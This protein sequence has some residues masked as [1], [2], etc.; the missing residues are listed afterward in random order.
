[1]L[2]ADIPPDL[3]RSEV[4]RVRDLR[5]ADRRARRIIGD[6]GWTWTIRPRLD[7]VQRRPFGRLIDAGVISSD[8]GDADAA[9]ISRIDPSDPPWVRGHLGRVSVSTRTARAVLA[10]RWQGLYTLVHEYLHLVRPKAGEGLIDA[11]ALDLMDGETTARL[12]WLH[13]GYPIGVE[14][15]HHLSARRA[16]VSDPMHPR[17]Q[18]IRAN[19]L[20]AV[21]R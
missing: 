17:A 18:R 19:W 5:A 13:A 10:G 8:V 2:L 16:R 15:L 4:I 3:P 14:R 6:A 7:S 20:R 9:T 12:T 21:A 1:M 11:V